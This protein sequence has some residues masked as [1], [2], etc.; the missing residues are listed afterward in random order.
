MTQR[1]AGAFNNY[2]KVPKY[3]DFRVMLDKQ[4]KEIDAVVVSTP[5]HTHAVASITA[6]KMGKHCYTEKPLT[7]DVY[8]ARQ[9]R[10]R[11]RQA[12]GGHADGQPGHRPAA[13]SAPASRSSG[14][15][16]SATSAKSTSGPTAPSGRKT[17]IGPRTAMKCPR[18]LNWDLWLGPAPERPYVRDVYHPFNWR[19]WWDFGTGALGDMACHTMNL[20]FMALR[21][22]APT[23]VTADVAGAA[24]CRKPARWAA[25]SPTNSRPADKLPACRLMW[26]ERRRPEAKLFH[27]QKPAGSGCLIIGSK[28][29][30]YSPVRLRRRLPPAAA[31]QFRQLQAAGTD[32]AAFARP[33]PG[34]DPRLQGRRPGHVQLRRLRRPAHRNRPA[35]QR[36]HSR[37]QT[38]SCWDSENLRAIDLPAADQYIRREYRKGWSL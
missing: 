23:S 33:S 32:A 34:M 29:T 9:M 28:G 20:P 6:M 21:L 16:S 38:R 19:G 27:G 2:P 35:R 17:S 3:S 5:D 1:A 14:P 25:R 11:R 7:H 26:Y 24:Q 4:G 10:D 36:R 37:R 15:A 30:L 22:G 8:E 18:P 31:G 12:Q 13:A